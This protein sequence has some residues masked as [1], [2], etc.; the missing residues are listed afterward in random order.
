[1]A[2]NRVPA[3]TAS[4]LLHGGLFALAFLVL[5]KAKLPE[6][7]GQATPVTVVSSA[8]EA[9]IRPAIQAPEPAPA[10]SEEPE[11]A[12]SPEP[13]AAVESPTLPA[14]PP[15]APRA[16]APPKPPPAAAAPALRPPPRPKPAAKPDLDLGKLADSLPAARAKPQT[17]DLGALASSLPS[18]PTRAAR[19]LDLDALTSSL[20]TGGARHTAAARGPARPETAAQA[21][22]AVGAATGLS[23]DELGALREKLIRLWN[24]N[25]D[26]PGAGSVI[27]RVRMR[28]SPDGSLAGAPELVDTSGDADAAVIRAASQRAISAVN[29][30][31]PYSEIPP[32][33][34]K[35]HNDIVFKFD[36]RQACR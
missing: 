8:P 4:A 17:L 36:A 26:V 24:L 16:V 35:V 33:Q 10:A 29:R 23:A 32:E 15:P 28:L 13:P 9:D 5:P 22:P 27:A 30:G 1:M 11:P 12:P 19:S 2:Q 6:L 20:P 18:R 31:A 34:L 14:P 7:I 3:L 21:R 25:C